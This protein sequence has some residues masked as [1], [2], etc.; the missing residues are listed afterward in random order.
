MGP[1]SGNPDP[2]RGD[3]LVGRARHPDGPG[4]PPPNSGDGDAPLARRCVERQADSSHSNTRCRGRTNGRSK[5]A[6]YTAR[7]AL[8]FVPARP[9]MRQ[10]V[11]FKPISSDGASVDASSLDIEGWEMSAPGLLAIGAWPTMCSDAC[12]SQ[13]FPRSITLTQ[14]FRF[15]VAGDIPTSLTVLFATRSPF[16]QRTDPGAAIDKSLPWV[17]LGATLVKHSNLCL[18]K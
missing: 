3:G 5:T 7:K 8:A 16:A 9:R 11:A 10:F 1:S 6:F 4:D 18:T 14:I 12:G 13:T 15:G 17:L 2:P